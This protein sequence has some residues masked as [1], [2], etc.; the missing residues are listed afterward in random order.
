L[1][2]KISAGRSTVL[3]VEPDGETT[4]TVAVIVWLLPG[5]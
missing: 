2:S 3:S 1:A 4:F 5:S